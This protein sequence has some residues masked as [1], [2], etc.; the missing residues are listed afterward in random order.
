MI[1]Y[2]L[3]PAPEKNAGRCE[4]SPKHHSELFS[5]F[6]RN[7]SQHGE[8]GNI[9]LE[10]LGHILEEV[11]KTIGQF[12]TRKKVGEIKKILFTFSFV[13][14][15][16]L[17][18]VLKFLFELVGCHEI[19]NIFSSILGWYGLIDINSVSLAFECRARENC[20]QFKIPVDFLQYSIHIVRLLPISFVVPMI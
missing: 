4:V 18:T 13:V 16:P 7:F 8:E 10:A 5:S 3:L 2:C 19:E 14:L 15:A 6:A 11:N 17:W 20:S 9:T 12:L 1:V